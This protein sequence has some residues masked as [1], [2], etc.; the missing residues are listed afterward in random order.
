M[1]N[2]CK[3]IPLAEHDVLVRRLSSDEDGEQVAACLRADGMTFELSGGF[4]DDIEK[5]DARFEAFDE[6]EAEDFLKAFNNLTKT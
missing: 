2:W 5:A 6:T 3:I 4:K 1:K